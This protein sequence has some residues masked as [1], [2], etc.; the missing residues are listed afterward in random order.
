MNTFK[1]NNATFIIREL[2][3]LDLLDGDDIIYWYARVLLTRLGYL[4]NELDTENLKKAPN[5]VWKR[6]NKFLELARVTSIEG[7]HELSGIGLID[8]ADKLFTL[9]QAWIRLVQS[10]PH[11]YKKWDDAHQATI[12]KIEDEKKAN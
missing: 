4:Q 1:H 7:E 8:D 5:F 11:L 3:G 6:V 9:Y 12:P 2:I 10:D